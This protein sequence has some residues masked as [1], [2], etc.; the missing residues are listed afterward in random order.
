MPSAIPFARLSHIGKALLRTVCGACL[1]LTLP[2]S[3]HNASAE[4]AAMQTATQK[5]DDGA[6]IRTF[7]GPASPP[8]SV[9]DVRTGREVRIHEFFPNPNDPFAIDVR[10]QLGEGGYGLQTPDRGLSGVIPAAS[11]TP[12]ALNMIPFGV[13]L[14]GALIDPSGPWYDGG[15][16]DPRNSFDRNCTGWEYEVLHPVV[17]KLVGLPDVSPGH[18]QPGGLF[19]YHGYP[20][21][22]IAGLRAQK[23]ASSTPQGAIA[24]GYSAD[25]Y[26]VIDYIIESAAGSGRPA[27]YLFSGYTLREGSRTAVAHT[28]PE[29]TPSGPYDGLYV[30]DYVYNPARKKAQIEAALAG[31]GEYQGLK[32]QD[33]KAGRAAYILLDDRNGH[34]LR[35]AEQVL[36]GY[37]A[38]H[39]T[40]VMTPDWPEVP[41]LFAFEPDASFKR[42]IPF[43]FERGAAGRMLARLGMGG[44]DG[45]KTLYN[46]CASR[47]TGVH[48]WEMRAPY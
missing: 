32:A 42:I 43:E 45:R 36:P 25:G 34:V 14:D 4:P 10:R 35:G 8:R 5:Q 37:P 46:N 1:C 7:A 38:A 39:Y 23:R 24:A 47:L 17:R 16:A 3:V 13:A 12:W 2:A 22:L 18:V 9:M 41:R 11:G 40:Y 33:V 21:L 15:P 19:H 31:Q 30:Q 27:L 20:G 29:F 26:P 28:N 48:A 6:I 44:P